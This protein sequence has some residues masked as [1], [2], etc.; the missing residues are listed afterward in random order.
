MNLIAYKSIIL[1]QRHAINQVLRY[2]RKLP[3]EKW[4]LRSMYIGINSWVKS[5]FATLDNFCKELETRRIAMEDIEDLSRKSKFDSKSFKH[6]FQRFV[7]R[8]RGKMIAIQNTA[9]YQK[10]LNGFCDFCDRNIRSIRI[11][12]EKH[13]G[14][15]VIRLRE[16]TN[17]RRPDLQSASETNIIPEIK[18]QSVPQ[19]SSQD[20]SN[21]SDSEKID[22]TIYEQ[23]FFDKETKNYI[24]IKERQ[25]NVFAEKA[26][27]DVI[28]EGA[29]S[30]ERPITAAATA[31]TA[32]NTTT[33]TST[34]TT[35]AKSP[36]TPLESRQVFPDKDIEATDNKSKEKE[37]H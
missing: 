1:P 20:K 24:P 9:G 32:I 22:T 36:F 3:E 13:L 10:A 35:A 27:K 2:S 25:E 26:I 6:G 29:T 15:E 14:D 33:T 34:T 21:K 37:K 5:K 17:K 7:C 19:I 23:V 4:V 16:K 12:L 8:S 30:L 18:V 11:Y 31:S 28:K